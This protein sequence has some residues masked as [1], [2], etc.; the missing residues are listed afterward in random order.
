[1]LARVLVIEDHAVLANA[2]ADALRYAGHSVDIAYDGQDGDLKATVTAYDVV[3][4]DRDL[5]RLHGDAVCQHIVASPHNTRVLILTATGAL[6]DRVAGLAAGA[7]DFLS[8][9]FE[10]AE[11]M[12]RVQALARR[13]GPRHAPVIRTGPFELDTNRRHLTKNGK[14]IALTT[15]ELAVVEILM[16]ANGRVVSTEELM[17]RAW[18]ENL[19]PFSSVVRVVLSKLRKKIGHPDPIV[20]LPGQGYRWTRT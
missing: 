16:T 7:D 12:A 11:L 5:P 10:L 18:D 8:K 9:P 15:K 13:S 19:D 20:T 2:I 3:V 4:L 17:E 6:E 1:M 14:P